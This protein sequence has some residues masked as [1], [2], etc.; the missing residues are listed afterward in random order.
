MWGELHEQKEIAISLPAITEAGKGNRLFRELGA[1][2]HYDVYSFEATAH[3]LWQSESILY[4]WLFRDGV[5]VDAQEDFDE[6]R[7]KFPFA[8]RPSSDQ[9]VALALLDKIISKF[10]G[11][12]TYQGNSFSSTSVQSDWDSCNNYLLKEW[13]EEPGSESL[14]RMIEENYA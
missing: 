5:E 4:V 11:V 2:L 3:E 1:T 14:R 12:A 7:I 10:S 9:S 13:G 8:T 6:I